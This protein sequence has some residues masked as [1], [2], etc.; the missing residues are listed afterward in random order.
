MDWRFLL[1]STS[2]NSVLVCGCFIDDIL[3]N[4][5]FAAER[6]RFIRIS[7]PCLVYCIFP[8]PARDALP[9]FTEHKALKSTCQLDK[10]ARNTVMR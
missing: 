2:H 3:D 8:N 1:Q 5:H 9:A 10:H 6:F 4:H 7:I